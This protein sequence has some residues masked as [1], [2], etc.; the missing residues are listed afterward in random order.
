M[1]G[2]SAGVPGGMSARGAV[3]LA[4]LAQAREQQKQAAERAA[5][6]AEGGE[7]AADLVVDV[8]TA[9]FQTKV[10]ERSLEVPVVVDLWATWC[11]PCKQLSPILEKLAQEANGAWVLAKVDVDAEPAIA[12]AF[13]VQSIPTVVA[14]VGG[15]PLPL[16]QGALPEAQLRQ[17]LDELVKAAAEA[18]LSAAPREPAAEEPVEPA[19]PLLDAAF[20]AFEAGDWD[21]AAAAYQQLLDA[22]PNDIDAKSGLVR[23][24]LMRR[25]E[26]QD[27]AA[28]VA[29]S[30]AAPKDVE[31]AC[32]A[33]DFELLA[34][35]ARA[36]FARL[37]K[38]VSL[39]QG[40]E[41]S[42]TRK[43]LLDLFELV[44]QSDPDVAAARNAL[45]SALF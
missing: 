21:G 17:I 19:N 11:G 29:A 42:T 44:G 6:R 15:R 7:T 28:A 36:A 13:Q 31:A 41:R 14:I 24:A 37:V 38:T 33:A 45:A 16:F 9:D 40:D 39:T 18:G 27:P 3:D 35:N 32:L 30:D 26:G 23:V 25:V 43:H 1:A 22:D 10:M 34:G 5:A 2:M 8:T 4:A 20:D 12:Q